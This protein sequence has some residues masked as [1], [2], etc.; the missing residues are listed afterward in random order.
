MLPY[1]ARSLDRCLL[2]RLGADAF[3]EA[4]RLPVL[5]HLGEALQLFAGLPLTM[6]LTW[7]AMV[8]LC[9]ALRLKTYERGETVVSQGEGCTIPLFI[10][11]STFSLR[12]ALPS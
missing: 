4:L 11:Y 12:L 3:E 2:L 9:M 7:E 6:S 1:S 5:G 10:L 8:E